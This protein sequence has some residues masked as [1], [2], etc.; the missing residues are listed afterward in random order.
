MLTLKIRHFPLYWQ[1]MRMHKP[2][3]TLLLL[4]PTLWSLWLAGEGKPDLAIALI[5]VAGTFVMRAAGCVINDYADRDFDRHV[6]RTRN[7]PLTS[8]QIQEAEALTIF[9]I[10]CLLA[11][12][13]VLLTNTLTMLLSLGGLALAICYPFMK[14]HTYLPQV[15]LGAA[16]SWG[17]PMAYTAQTGT[18]PP[19]VWLIYIANL[20]WTVTY[21][22]F[23]AMVDRNDDLKVGI[24]STAILFGDN[25]RVATAALQVT[26]LFALMLVGQRFELSM[27]YFTSLGLA[28]CLFAYQQYLVSR[29]SR[30]L[31]FQAFMN[32]NWVGL[33]IFL[34]IVGHFWLKG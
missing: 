18:I 34:G 27:V 10:L 11:A 15:V 17:I 32:N 14:R 30:K 3:G 31:Y 28:A 5:F 22:T 9:T 6:E 2:I 19:E 23:Y 21:D 33:V 7:R 12:G 25:D 26:T 4:W 1:L 29:R 20:L 8:G 16:F 13:L 24:K